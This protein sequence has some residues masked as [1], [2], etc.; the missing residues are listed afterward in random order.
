MNSGSSH[1]PRSAPIEDAAGG[2]P[3]SP[4]AR[5]SRPAPAQDPA[6]RPD[7][8]PRKH[9]MA[10]LANAPAQ[11]VKD[12]WAAF[13]APTAY[14]CVRGPESGLIAL[15][16]RIGGDGPPFHFGEAMIT[17]ATV[18]LEDGTIGHASMLGRDH[19]KVELAALI[20]A[21]AE[22]E[23]RAGEIDEAIIQPLQ[24]ANADAEAEAA[25]RTRATRVDF[26]TMV[27]GED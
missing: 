2:D 4:L 26:F 15:R 23:M 14:T 22:D 1:I 8:A 25:A 9:R 17:R 21:M 6:S 7:A 27:R 19:E 5:E 13:D 12:A 10:V 18:R 3:Q 20:D 16:G 24:S 11:A